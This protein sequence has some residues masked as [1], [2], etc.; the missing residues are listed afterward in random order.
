MPECPQWG[1]GARGDETLCRRGGRWIRR[2]EKSEVESVRNTVERKTEIKK[3][4]LAD[5]LPV[6]WSRE[7][8]YISAAKCDKI[9]PIQ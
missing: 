3:V 7:C 1:G 6:V 2:K 9:S 5:R 4:L 8:N